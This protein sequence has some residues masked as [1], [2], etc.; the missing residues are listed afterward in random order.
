MQIKNGE[1]KGKSITTTRLQRLFVILRGIFRL[2][3]QANIRHYNN[4]CRMN[5]FYPS[6]ITIKDKEKFENDGWNILL[7][8]MAN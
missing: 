4:N 6:I 5:I 1:E 8:Y 2:Q 3:L 7:L